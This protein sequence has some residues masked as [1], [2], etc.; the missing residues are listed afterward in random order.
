MSFGFA[1]GAL[2]IGAPVLAAFLWFTPAGNLSVTI[3][4]SAAALFV[5]LVL[6]CLAGRVA[7]AGCN[8]VSRV[9]GRYSLE[10]VARDHR[11]Q[12]SI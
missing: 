6:S 4:V 3:L 5:V 10:K 9:L 12:R 2:A 11:L 8:F 7:A 1:L